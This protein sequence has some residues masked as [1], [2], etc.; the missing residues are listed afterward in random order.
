MN[1][2]NKIHIL[3]LMPPDVRFRELSSLIDFI[4]NG[5]VQIASEDLN[6]FLALAKQFKIKGLTEDTPG[7]HRCHN[8]P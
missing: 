1:G 4:Y 8:R 2:P 6:S 7:S 3:Q 5:K